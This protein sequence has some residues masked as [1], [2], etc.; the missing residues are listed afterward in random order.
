[1]IQEVVHEATRGTDDFFEGRQAN[2]YSATLL[3]PRD[4]MLRTIESVD[5]T[6]WPALYRLAQ[7]FEVT[8]SALRIR[9]EALGLIHVAE[10]R[11]IHRS[12]AE[13][14]GQQRLL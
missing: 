4:L 11:S 1:V 13:Y 6:S 9:L 10:D 2:R 8:I 5:L 12:K 3:M 14:L 7:Q